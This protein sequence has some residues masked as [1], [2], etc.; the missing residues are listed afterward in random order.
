MPSKKISEVLKEEAM[1]EAMKAER[2]QRALQ[3]SIKDWSDKYK[4]L[5][6][7]YGHLEEKY[8]DFI[9]IESNL[10]VKP[11]TASK[12]KSEKHEATAF[13][14]FSDWHIEE[15]VD[16]SQTHGLN[17]YNPDIAKHRAQKVTQ[18]L[19]KLVNKER[20][21]VQI[22]NLVI[23]LGGDFIGNWIHEELA[24]TNYMTPIEA[25]IE[26]QNMLTASLEYL[27]AHGDFE[28]IIA[29]C[30]VGNHGRIT[31][32]MQYA[33]QVKTNYE[34]AIYNTIAKFI[35]DDRLEIVF[36]DSGV[37]YVEIYNKKLRFYHGHQV[38]FKDGVGGL[39]IPLNKKQQRWDKTI[40]ADYNSMCHWHYFSLPNPSTILNGTLKG[41]DTFAAECGFEYQPPQQAFALFDSKY[42]R[43]ITAPIFCE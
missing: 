27:L 39:T 15:R 23:H 41:W 30:S 40:K 10:K 29:L 9:H 28:R 5:L 16:K 8:N 24:Q 1:K 36:P 14:I 22:K 33:N 21:A 12:T 34:Y 20:D 32:K 31:P 18:N 7:D 35:K 3:A 25:T 26:A 11:I 6:K 13:A 4:L 43:T 37:G 42:G 19:V 38:R 2:V 17:E